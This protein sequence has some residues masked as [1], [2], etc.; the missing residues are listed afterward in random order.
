MNEENS[1]LTIEI[2]VE[3]K[4][5]Y[6]IN[7]YTNDNNQNN[8]IDVN[9][10]EIQQNIINLYL[11]CVISAVIRAK[12]LIL[13]LFVLV[14]V[15]VPFI[16][17]DLYYAIIYHD[18]IIKTGNH[19]IYTYLMV[20][21]IHRILLLLYAVIIIIVAHVDNDL[22]SPKIK[23]IR[24]MF[25]LTNSTFVL[26]LSCAGIIL[27]STITNSKTCINPTYNYIIVSIIFKI[28]AIAVDIYNHKSR[29]NTRFV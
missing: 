21:G 12:T 6:V 22:N 2:E 28:L 26:I 24:S 18:C 1:G 5:S 4:Q 23:I 10:P 19:S 14:L 29:L 11:S 3:Q 8:Q 25:E 15:Y 20:S 27:I 13:V 17:F 9:P 16:V 7:V